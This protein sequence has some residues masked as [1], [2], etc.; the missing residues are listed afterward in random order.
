MLPY[1]LCCADDAVDGGVH[2]GALIAAAVVPALVLLVLI[3]VI[4]ALPCHAEKKKDPVKNNNV[5]YMETGNTVL[6]V[7]TCVKY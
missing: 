7:Q 3:P 1:L 2:A 5:L 4:H 6:Y